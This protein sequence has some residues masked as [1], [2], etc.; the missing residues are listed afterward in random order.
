MP[1][2]AL[3]GVD[4][5]EIQRAVETGIVTLQKAAE[6]YGVSF[7]TVRKRAAREEWAT[8]KRIQD[9][10]QEMRAA[11]SQADNGTNVPEGNVPGMSQSL[12]KQPKTVD[13]AAKSLVEKQQD[14]DSIVHRTLS[15]LL[16]KADK[17]PPEIETMGDYEKAVKL[18]RLVLKMDTGEAKV[19]LNIWGGTSLA[20]AD[21]LGGVREVQ[22][23]GEA[24]E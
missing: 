12:Q 20:G 19:S 23:V 11:M 8:P 21:S 24:E 14:H 7:E 18:H 4:W 17:A 1:A 15:R 5:T 22:E 13:L 3:P 10:A 2:A 6:F 9:R 16:V